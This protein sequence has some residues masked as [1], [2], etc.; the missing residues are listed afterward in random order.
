MSLTQFNF[1]DIHFA[2]EFNMTSNV[3]ICCSMNVIDIDSALIRCMYLNK[4]GFGS[5][6]AK[7]VN[8]K[9]N[10]HI[11]IMTCSIVS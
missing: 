8:N 7:I 5:I 3:D 9:F 10:Y 2:L 6:P 1:N 4:P 11:W